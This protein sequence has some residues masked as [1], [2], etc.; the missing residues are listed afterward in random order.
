MPP[1][2]ENTTALSITVMK[3][4]NDHKNDSEYHENTIKNFRL[5]WVFLRRHYSFIILLVGNT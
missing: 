2:I 3:V 4:S 5:L 1:T